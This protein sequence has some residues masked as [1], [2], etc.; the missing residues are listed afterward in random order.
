MPK[1]LNVFTKDTLTRKELFY[2][3]KNVSRE[4]F[5]TWLTDN[6]RAI[7]CYHAGRPI[8]LTTYFEHGLRPNN[9]NQ[10]LESFHNFLK[11][12]NYVG[13]IDVQET[14]ELFKGKSDRFVYVILDKYDFIDQA[15]HYWIYGSEFML[16]LAQNTAYHLKDDLKKIGTPTIFTCDLPFDLIN[17]SE[18]ISLYDRIKDTNGT[19]NQMLN[20]IFS[21]YTIII[22]NNISPHCIIAHEHPTERV[23]DFHAGGYYQ[24][25]MVYC[26]AC[27]PS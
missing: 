13:K 24:N 23:Q 17:N 3:K 15:P 1:P 2:I 21:N 12:V 5:A 4:N 22:E 11:T 8:D 20:D 25:S 19:F 26:E 16:C 9:L 10:A 18:L 14:V 27:Q 7:R 6:F